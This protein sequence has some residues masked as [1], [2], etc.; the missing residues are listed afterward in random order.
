MGNS[1]SKDEWL[2]IET[3]ETNNNKNNNERSC[4]NLNGRE[5]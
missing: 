3:K 1:P 4:E 2:V 5:N